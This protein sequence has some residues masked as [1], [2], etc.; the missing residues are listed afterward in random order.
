[1]KACSSATGPNRGRALGECPP[2]IAFVITGLAEGGAETQVLSLAKHFR[3][4]GW[5]VAVVSLLPLMGL[6]R[7]LDPLGIE[8]VSLGMR[9]PWSAWIA[10]FR[11]VRFLRRFR[12]TVVHA[13]M[14]HANLLARLARP[15]L[16]VGVLICTAHSPYEAPRGTLTPRE[17]T[18]REWAYRLTDP[19]CHLTTQVSQAGVERYVRVGA[20]PRG[21]IRAVPN[22]VDT[23][24]FRPDA[25]ARKRFRE[26]MGWENA[27]VWL[28]VGRFDP[29]KDHRTMI[30]AFA[31]LEEKSA[32]LG[33]VGDG[34]L[35]K[36]IEECVQSLGIAGRVE[37][38]GVRKDVQGLMTSADAYVLSSR[39]EG[40]PM[41]LLEAQ[42]CALPVVATGVGGVVEVVRDGETG[43]LVPAGN[44]TALAAA[45]RKL[46]SLS[47]EERQAMGM[48]G[49]L[50][51]V[52]N[53][54]LHKVGSEWEKLFAELVQGGPTPPQTP[55]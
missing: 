8:V 13:H 16:P 54:S 7:E 33:L 15:F 3:T 19:F 9:N 4:Q 47:P 21:K 45:M 1:M 27:F 6:A 39:W 25:A 2:R 18:W 50:W 10:W 12:P 29:A 43:F 14:F 11:L 38:L 20:V 32:V 23:G 55:P 30:E 42:A 40:M 36:E 46:M 41:T 53:F 34:P 44:P 49:R 52:C 48:A 24:R 31:Q 35:R 37:F 28:S 22:G 5:R 17:R 26:Q 51:V